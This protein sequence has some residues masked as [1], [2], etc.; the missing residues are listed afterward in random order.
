MITNIFQGGLGN[1]LFQVATGLSFALD[2]NDNY[3]L[4][5]ATFRGMVGAMHYI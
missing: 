3:V 4:N 5:P 1:Q 2:N